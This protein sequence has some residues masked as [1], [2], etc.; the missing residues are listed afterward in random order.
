M[1][2]GPTQED[3]IFQERD[4]YNTVAGQN[5]QMGNPRRLAVGEAVRRGRVAR[6]T[7]V[8][9]PLPPANPDGV[10]QTDRE[11]RKPPPRATGKGLRN[12]S[13]SPDVVWG[14]NALQNAG[15]PSKIR[16]TYR[17]QHQII[18]HRRGSFCRRRFRHAS[19]EP[20]HDIHG[21]NLHRN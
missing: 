5:P 15:M 1:S 8:K 6:P 13:L 4:I 21:E 11:A 19:R 18:G 14:R 3:H 10:L 20:S 2:T 7:R 9:S 12:I 16:R 17:V